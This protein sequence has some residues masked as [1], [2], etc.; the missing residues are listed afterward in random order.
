[1]GHMSIHRNHREEIDAALR[2]HQAGEV[3]RLH[4]LGHDDPLGDLFRTT[5]PKP[6]CPGVRTDGRGREWYSAAWIDLAP[7]EPPTRPVCAHPTDCDEIGNVCTYDDCPYGR[8][9]AP[10]VGFAGVDQEGRRNN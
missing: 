5:R 8:K 1:M 10:F 3:K 7:A 6:G 9:A 4:T 2:R